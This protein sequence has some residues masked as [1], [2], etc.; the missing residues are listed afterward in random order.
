VK[1]SLCFEMV[2]EVKGEMMRI[3]MVGSNKNKMIK[4]ESK[5]AALAF[6]RVLLLYPFGFAC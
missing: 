1:I 3:W 4:G 6:I 2:L 5:I